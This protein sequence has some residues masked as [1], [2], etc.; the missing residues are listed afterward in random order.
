VHLGSSPALIGFVM[1][2]DN[3]QRHTLD[4]IINLEHYTIN[5][6][7]KEFYQEAHQCSANYS[8]EESE[9]IHSGLS[10]HYIGNI[11]APFV[12]ESKMKYAVTFKECLPISLNSTQLI[13]GEIIHIICDE[14]VIQPDGYIDIEA[15]NTVSLSGMDS[16]HASKRLSRLSYAKP[17][18]ALK[19]LAI[20]GSPLSFSDTKGSK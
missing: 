18:V 10:A 1:R 3:G 16:Y 13:I 5:H 15:L 14:N 19:R 20:S 8:R 12:K 6:V 9:F 2:P 17:D 11:K 7:S 4:N